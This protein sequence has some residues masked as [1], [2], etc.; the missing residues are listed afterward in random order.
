MDAKTLAGLSM[1]AALT[2]LTILI[3]SPTTLAVI[4]LALVGALYV[5]R[6]RRQY[7]ET[8]R[9]R[10]SRARTAALMGARVC[11]SKA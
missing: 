10:K 11:G 4:E 6:S 2:T 1:A 3:A 5:V 8:H 7:Q 9:A